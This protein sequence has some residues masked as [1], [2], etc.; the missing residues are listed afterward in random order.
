[1]TS[2]VQWALAD[3]RSGLHHSPAELADL[4]LAR[5]RKLVSFAYE[6][7]DYYRNL[8]SSVGF[9]PRHLKRLADLEAIPVTTRASL[10]LIP[11][12][13]VISRGY[14][15]ERLRPTRTGGSSGIPLT[16]YRNWRESRFGLLWRLRTWFHHGLRWNDHVMTICSRPPAR[17]GRNL[18]RSLPLP[19]HLNAAVLDEPDALLE[20]LIT[21]NPTV[22]YG[23]SFTVATLAALA[24]AKKIPRG[25][26]RLVGTSGDMLLPRFKQM[27]R[28]AWDI[29]PIDIYASS[30]AGDIAWQCRRREQFHLNGDQ[31][32]VELLRNGRPV[33]AG[34]EGEVV[35]T[36]MYRYAMPLIRYS[37]GD[38]A[39]P[40]ATPCPC[41]VSLPTIQSLV[42]RT[43]NVVPLPDGRVYLGFNVILNNIQG[44]RRF[45]VVQPALDRFQINIVPESNHPPDMLARIARVVGEHLGSG[46]Q[47]EVRSVTESDLIQTSLKPQP[48]IPFAPVDF[49]NAPK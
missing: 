7:V 18:I 40:S 30:E 43:L 26:L 11:A 14:R 28:E 10:Q 27:I 21:L 5:L 46:I 6:N 17:H 39:V 44:I 8:F 13:R 29:E 48:V 16:V 32:Y 31:T 22:L 20:R 37:P 19:W 23:Y 1:M 3:F 35:L 47:I 38:L 33:H 4:Q 25:S 12:D 34:E 24:T 41:E 2:R 15:A 49:G 36:H 9:Q 45:Q 42:G